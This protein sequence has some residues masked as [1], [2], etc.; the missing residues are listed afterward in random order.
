MRE[1][2]RRRRSQCRRADEKLAGLT[3]ATAQA[4]DGGEPSRSD[5]GW[6]NRDFWLSIGLAI[7]VSLVWLYFRG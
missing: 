1:P 5:A 4:L 2:A 3:F 7:C 6:C